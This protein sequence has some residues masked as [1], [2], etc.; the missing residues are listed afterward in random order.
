MNF[1][2]KFSEQNS[3]FIAKFGEVHSV[4]DGGYER[5]YADGYEDGA[6]IADALIGRTI[7]GVYRNETLDYIG[8]SAFR[9]CSKLTELDLPMLKTCGQEAA[10]Q[11]SSLVKANLP[12]CEFLST[13][14][15]SDCF[16]LAAL[17]LRKRCALENVNAFNNTDIK[18]G[19][20][21]IYVLAA[22]VEWFQS[23]TNWSTLSTQFRA[24]ED[25][26]EICGE[27]TT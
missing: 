26:P 22:D 20:G 9:G 11:C 1:R 24:I 12:S 5:G 4:S 27:V 16:R 13:Q 19:N 6:E 17:I 2:V 14:M 10:R 25:Y 18:K 8:Q 23:A 21:Y 3:G 15:F 7:S